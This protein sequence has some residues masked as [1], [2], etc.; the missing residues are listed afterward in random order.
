MAEVPQI[1]DCTLVGVFGPVSSGKTHLLGKLWIPSM[2]R[3]L[4]LDI[5]AQFLGKEFTH[6][7]HNPQSLG[8]Q[9]Q[10]NPYYYR[11]AYHP[12]RENLLRDYEWAVKF[13]WLMDQPRWLIVDEAHEVCSVNFIPD[14]TNMAIRYSRFVKLGIVWTSQRLADVNKLLTSNCRMVVL[15]YTAEARELD[16]IRE[17]YGKNV[18]A[19]VKALRPCIYDDATEICHQEP[20]CLVWV[21]GRGTRVFALGDKVANIS[22]LPIQGQEITCETQALQEPRKQQEVQSSE[23]PSG[24]PLENQ[25]QESSPE[26]GKAK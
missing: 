19:Q 11:I 9:L 22:A 13:A 18:E 1:V 17:R 8:L 6:I 3:S 5:A 4:S 15:F 2:E 23:H 20:E 14:I 26:P 24:M 25:S 16:A 12:G 21:R 10:Q 7:W